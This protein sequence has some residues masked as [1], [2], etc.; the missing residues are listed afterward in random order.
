MEDH[1]SDNE[2]QELLSVHIP[3]TLDDESVGKERFTSVPTLWAVILEFI[4]LVILLVNI[5]NIMHI[6]TCVFIFRLVTTFIYFWM[7][8]V[9]LRLVPNSR[10][11][12][13]E[14]YYTYLHILL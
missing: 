4:I 7:S 3:F 12:F 2:S 13:S 14:V 10:P 6:L 8:T 11:S 9:S 5:H 1:S